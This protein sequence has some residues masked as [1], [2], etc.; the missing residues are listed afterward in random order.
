MVTLTCLKLVWRLSEFAFLCV[1]FGGRTFLFCGGNMYWI[2]LL[3]LLIVGGVIY[4]IISISETRCQNCHK[5]F[6]LKET[7]RT[8]IK[9]EKTSKIERHYNYNKKGQR[10]SSRD[11]RVYGTCFTYHVTYICKHCGRTT[12]KTEHK[13]VY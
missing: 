9:K 11:V 13:D 12:T 3:P 10:T 1:Y 4:L 7:N 2:F 6:A 5:L 8:L